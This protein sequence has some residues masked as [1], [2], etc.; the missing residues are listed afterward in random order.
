LPDPADA[1]KTE[2][3]GNV[4]WDSID[5]ASGHILP[6]NDKAGKE[7]MTPSKTVVEDVL[8]A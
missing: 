8:K 4:D 5:A 2:K 3:W 6:E 1:F 7:R